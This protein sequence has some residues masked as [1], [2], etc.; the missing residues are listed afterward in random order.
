M[1]IFRILGV[2]LKYVIACVGGQAY[3]DGIRKINRSTQSM[4]ELKNGEVYTR[5][6]NPDINQH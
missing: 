1:I 3:H 6:Y 2:L 4:E 5:P